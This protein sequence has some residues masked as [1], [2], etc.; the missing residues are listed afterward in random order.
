MKAD[1]E[2]YKKLIPLYDRFEPYHYLQSYLR[3]CRIYYESGEVLLKELKDTPVSE[4]LTRL[5]FLSIGETGFSLPEC[6]ILQI[7]PDMIPLLEDTDPDY[8]DLHLPFPVMFV[9]HQFTIGKFRINGFMMADLKELEKHG[10]NVD[11]DSDQQPFRVLAVVMN[12]EDNYEFFSNEPLGARRITNDQ[13]VFADSDKEKR[14]MFYASKLINKIGANLISLIINDEREIKTFEL[15]ADPVQNQKRIKR[16]KMPH[17][18]KLVIR[19]SDRLSAY[20]KAY[21]KKRGEISIRFLVRGH[22]FHFWNTKKYAHLY[23]EFARAE[24]EGKRLTS[25]KV[26]GNEAIEVAYSIDG[27][28]VISTWIYPHYRGEGEALYTNRVVEV[29]K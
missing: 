18:D 8:S 16:G 7:D 10:L 17:K 27:K 24:A 12:T 19:L 29:R 22:R 11:W 25:L 21:A 13:D 3:S 5:R 15:R 14:E 26:L 2:D 1:Q 20:A 6:R 4:H 9:N 23:Q 28:G